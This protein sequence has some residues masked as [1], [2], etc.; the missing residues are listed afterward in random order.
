V[1]ITSKENAMSNKVRPFIPSDDELVARGQSGDHEAIGVLFTRH[2][3]LVFAA[4]F[5]ITK[6]VAD[7]EDVVQETFLSTIRFI[8]AFDGRSNIKTWLYRIAVNRS[9]MIVRRIK[10]ASRYEVFSADE[11][12]EE[13]GR[14]KIDFMC[15][16]TR[17]SPERIAAAIETI[18]F[19]RSEL[20]FMSPKIRTAFILHVMKDLDPTEVL[21]L[22]HCTINAFKARLYRA[23]HQLQFAF[24]HR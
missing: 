19:I 23:R 14:R 7:A 10:A 17:Q 22:S 8:G 3:H 13:A 18:E 12:V 21:E 11:P 9:L 15:G 16:D 4:G 24:S 1:I 20:V 6:N 5:R 2:R